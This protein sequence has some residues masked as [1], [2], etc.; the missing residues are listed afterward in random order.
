MTKNERHRALWDA[1][2]VI[3]A[4]ASIDG[5]AAGHRAEGVILT[6]KLLGIFDDHDERV[7][8]ARFEVCPGHS[9]GGQVWCA[10]CG[11]LPDDAPVTP[12]PA[13]G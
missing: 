9:G 10:Y 11:D 8:M 5:H 3:Y 7:W 4:N 1:L 2:E 6:A 12:E 13:D